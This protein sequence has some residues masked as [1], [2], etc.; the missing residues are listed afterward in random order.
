MREYQSRTIQELVVCTC[1]RCQ[2]RLT[3]D[4]PG[5]WQERLSFDHTGSF[6]SV[7]GDGN[8]VSLDLC[9]HCT[10]EVLGQ[11][12]R[13]TPPADADIFGLWQGKTFESAWNAPPP[14]DGREIR[15]LAEHVIAS[16]Q[17]ASN[18][19]DDTLS[20]NVE[21][22]KRFAATAE[23]RGGHEQ[24]AHPATEG[25]RGTKYEQDVVA[26]ANEQAALLRASKFSALDIG[27]IA[28]E[29]EDVAKSEQRELAR[30]MAMLLAH[31]LQWQ[32]QPGQRGASWE[33]T[34]RTQRNSIK[35]RIRKTPSL[36]TSLEDADWWA[37]AWGDAVATATEATGLNAFPPVC[38]W[39][40]AQVLNHEFFPDSS[41]KRTV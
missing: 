4:E 15:A 18:A 26:W 6:D 39:S 20:S 37:D 35:R 11:W 17:E 27:H 1:D 24:A 3:P 34:I 9:Q 41:S 32:F 38:P 31:L 22:N 29:L 33:A 13:I 36:A 5:E 7:F 8:T 2:R 12:L 10:R 19:L 28:D 23:S 25:T 21:S 16:T 14:E 30:R 40:A